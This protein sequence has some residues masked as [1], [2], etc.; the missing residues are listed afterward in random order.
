[1]GHVVTLVWLVCISLIGD[2]L[3]V[4]NN[5]VFI[6][7]I[8]S[9]D[10]AHFSTVFQKQIEES[11]SDALKLYHSMLGLSS[12]SEKISNVDSIC[13][14]LNKP[15]SSPD[16]AFF[17]SVGKKLLDPAKC[18]ISAQEVEK[19]SQQWLAQDISA[20]NLFY[21]ISSMKNL[22]IKV[23]ANHITSLVNKIKAKDTSPT[24]TAFILQILS[25]LGLTKSVLSGYISSINDVLDQA[26]EISGI[27]LFYDKGLYTTSLVANGI[28]TFLNGYGEVPKNIEDKLVKLFNYLYAHRQTT[29]TRAAAYMVAAFKS[30]ADSTVMLPI[31]IESSVGIIED[32]G[33]TLPSVVTVDRGNP[34]LSLRLKHFWTGAYLKSSEF[35]VKANG[36][37]TTDKKNGKDQVLV[38]SSDRGLFKQDE[39]NNI[40]QLS[41]ISDTKTVSILSGNYGLEI[42]VVINNVQVPIRV[43]TDVKISKITVTLQD[44]S[45]ERHISDISLTPG[46]TY[47]A[48]TVTGAISLEIGQQITI[49]IHLT[50]NDNNSLTAHQVFVQL[51]HEKTLQSITYICTE[52]IEDKQSGKKSYHLFLD[53]DVSAAE[54]DYLSGVYKAELFVGDSL[55]K[56]PLIWHMFNLELY[57]V[58]EAG[59]ETKHRIAQ[60]TDISRQQSSSPAA[61]KRAFSPNAIIGFGPTTAKLE[62]EHIFRAPEKRAPVILALTFTV[63]C[64]LPLLGLLIVWMV[65]GFN[66]SNFKFSM[67]NIIFHA[68]LI[69]I[70]YL[71]FVYWCRLDMFTTLGYLTILGI[72]TFLAGHCVLR[73]QVIAKKTTTSVGTTSQQA[74]NMK[75]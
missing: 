37:F 2:V 42:T 68:G 59:Q 8:S 50:D 53:P 33:H 65:I 12:L 54:F 16:L 70:C 73:G 48:S 71:Y 4:Q 56:T 27:Q 60:A 75:K 45:H 32:L 11:L 51:T 18:K 46:V 19:L 21:L 47:K 28:V 38:G 23:D 35:N 17:A 43:V 58:G 74:Y 67:S 55:I 63:L 25:Q 72:P 41:L 57:F 10:K 20:E 15:V 36:L 5:P 22:G 40:F 34:N 30:L 6:G 24:T 29:N 49:D 62:I 13:S 61:S 52:M 1:M 66:V 44:N 26:D 14:T 69:S 39:K 3:T 9:R 7:S 64:L 31:V